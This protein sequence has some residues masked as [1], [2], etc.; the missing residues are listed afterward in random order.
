MIGH[1][2]FPV[3]A[4]QVTETAFSPE[5]LAQAETVFT[6]ANG[7]L[8]LRGNLDEGSPAESAGTYLNGFYE[9]RP[10]I[11]GERHH[12]FPPTS[13]TQLNVTDGKVI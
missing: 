1:P 7:Y 11:Y 12:A 2:A 8:G 5:V 13:E 4:W 9:S 10:I 3:E 6:L